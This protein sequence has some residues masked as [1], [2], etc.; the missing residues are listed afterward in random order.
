MQKSVLTP[1]RM[2]IKYL[3]TPSPGQQNLGWHKQTEQPHQ[4]NHGD[5]K[6]PLLPASQQ[7]SS[8]QL[9]PS[10]GSGAGPAEAALRLSAQ[11]GHERSLTGTEQMQEL[12]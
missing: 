12:I 10:A 1:P 4:M 9:C 8:Q 5:A 11:G 2:R 3:T 7:L 6:A